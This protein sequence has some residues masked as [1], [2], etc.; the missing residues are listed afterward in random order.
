MINVGGELGSSDGGYYSTSPQMAYQPRTPTTTQQLTPQTPNTPTIIL[1]GD[2]IIFF[3]VFSNCA[4]EWF[5]FLFEICIIF[6][7][8]L[9]F[10][11][12]SK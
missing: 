5:L 7:I 10:F 6:V 8:I 4:S 1:T 12:L 3:W 9:F 11:N 2:F